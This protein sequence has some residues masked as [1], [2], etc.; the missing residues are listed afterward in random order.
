MAAPLP[1]AIYP[2]GTMA[3][4]DIYPTH[5]GI[6]SFAW[7]C[8]ELDLEPS[9][10]HAY[11]EARYGV[12]PQPGDRRDAY[13]AGRTPAM[14]GLSARAKARRARRLLSATTARA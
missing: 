12:V 2:A 10:L 9:T 6:G 4:A 8:D 14:I 11:A 7:L 3:V 13:M 5:A 1:A